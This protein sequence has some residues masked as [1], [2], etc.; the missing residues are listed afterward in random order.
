MRSFSDSSQIFQLIE[1][2]W[3]V[4]VPTLKAGLEE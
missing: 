2:E 3:V 4:R 1:G